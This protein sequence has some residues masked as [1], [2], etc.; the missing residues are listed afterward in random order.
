MS[1]L[2]V[3]MMVSVLTSITLISFIP[4]GE[5]SGPGTETKTRPPTVSASL[6][7]G[8]RAR[9]R[10]DGVKTG[11]VFVR[12]FLARSKTNILVASWADTYAFCSW[13]HRVGGNVSTKKT[14]GAPIAEIK[15]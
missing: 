11:M 6:M 2:R 4:W 14:N 3:L 15:K 5:T 12:A 13:A 7:F 9:P 8:G 1:V 10:G